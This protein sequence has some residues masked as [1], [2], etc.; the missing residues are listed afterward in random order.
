[1][2]KFEERKSAT[3]NKKNICNSRERKKKLNS[4]E[5]VMSLTALGTSES[6]GF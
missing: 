1:M 4:L 2:E 3:A 5:N 6:K